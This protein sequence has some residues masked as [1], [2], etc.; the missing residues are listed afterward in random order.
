VEGWT[1]GATFSSGFTAGAG[2]DSAGEMGCDSRIGCAKEIDCG[3]G[4]VTHQRMSPPVSV[5]T[6]LSNI[7]RNVAALCE[8]VSLTRISPIRISLFPPPAA[9]LGSILIVV[10]ALQITGEHT[11]T[12]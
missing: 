6:M 12:A 3:V 4:A 2:L 7:R 11:P 10:V 9:G 1:D 8:F 5:A